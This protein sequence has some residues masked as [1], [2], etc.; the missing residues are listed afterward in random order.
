M[1]F[2]AVLRYKQRVNDLSRILLNRSAFDEVYVEMPDPDRPEPA[3]IRATSWLYCFYFESGRISLTYLRKLGE[4]YSLVDKDT[5]EKHIDL[6]RCLRTEL[7]HNL[8]FEDSDQAARTT[9]QSWRKKACGTAKPRDDDQWRHCY[10]HLV[11]EASDLLRSI[12]EVVRRIE[13]DGDYGARQIEEWLHRLERNWPAAAFDPLIEDAKCRLGRQATDT[14]VFRRRHLDRWRKQI[15]VLEDGFDF[16]YEAT[17]LIEK[18][19]IDEDSA[20]L[21]ITGQDIIESLQIRPGPKIGSLLE[22]A[23]KRF[24]SDRC[25]KEDL[26]SYLR[27][28]E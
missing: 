18:T 11:I 27:T 14:I 10:E 4:A 25:T 8:G 2:E 5:A 19:L 28:I 17:R 3:F 13:A 26:I 6:V 23:R 21:P 9:A 16:K 24:D 20:V 12:D 15:E 7:H 22:A 1:S